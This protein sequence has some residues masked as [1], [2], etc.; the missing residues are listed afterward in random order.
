V[1]VAVSD[2]SKAYGEVVALEGVNLRADSQELLV[3][4]GPS[5]SGKTTLLRC[6]AGLEVADSGRVEVGG[7]DV[8]GESP[9]DRDVAMVFQ[10]YA[11]Y[12]HLDAASNIGFGLRARKL[13]KHMVD[14]KVLGAARLLR[15]E[16]CLG[17]VPDALSG[18]ER[19]RVALARAIVREPSA[20]LMD[21]PLANLDAELRARTRAEIRT[22]QRH[23]ETTM[24]YVTHDQTEA[25]TLGDRVAVLNTGRV[26]QV[27]TPRELYDSPA[28][29]F[30]ARFFGTPPM[31]LLDSDIQRAPD[32]VAVIGIRAER[33]QVVDRQGGRLRGTIK[34]I[35]RIGS[36]SIVHL[37]VSGTDV[38]AT[39]ERWA[40]HREGEEVGLDYS[41][42][43][44]YRFGPDGG[45][46]P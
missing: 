13:D 11:L 37:D 41:D 9:G 36:Q 26:T 1:T 27:G 7:Q 25:F 10:E 35:D 45:A 12:P 28:N 20:F 31:N 34:A 40:E 6:I 15:I 38:V 32:D 46:L 19:Q 8:T 33:I 17:R 5:G 2:L 16:D 39:G 23:L 30:V 29:T 42:S 21:E 44:V 14:E 18:G 24:I 22:L 4:V 3:V 43:D